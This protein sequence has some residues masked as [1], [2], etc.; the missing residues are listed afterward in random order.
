MTLVRSNEYSFNSKK[1][2][3]QKDL[4]LDPM[5]KGKNGPSHMQMA[6]NEHQ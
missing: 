2:V 1:K 4:V 5:K 3:T 6:L